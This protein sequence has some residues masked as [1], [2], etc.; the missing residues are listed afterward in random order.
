MSILS[1]IWSVDDAYIALSDEDQRSR[2][3]KLAFW[4]GVMAIGLAPVVLWIDYIFPPGCYRKSISAYFYEPRSGPVFVFILAYVSAFMFRY[5]G[6][7]IWDGRL[8]TAAAVFAIIVAVVPTDLGVFCSK[9]GQEV[10]LRG[11]ITY[12]VDAPSSLSVDAGLF[13]SDS[14]DTSRLNIIRPEDLFSS[15]V[16][17]HVGA[18]VLLLLILLY[19]TAIAHRIIEP[20]RKL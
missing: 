10:D 15:A 4:I 7:N 13:K 8:A 17:L 12:A 19:F 20:Y 2:Q 6:E 1:T 9:S 16:E 14:N 3:R 11:S 5:R 18:A